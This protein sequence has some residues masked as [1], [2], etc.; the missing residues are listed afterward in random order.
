MLI[1]GRGHDFPI[2]DKRSVNVSPSGVVDIVLDRVIARY[3]TA[4]DEASGDQQLCSVADAA[5]DASVTTY[6]SQES[7]VLSHVF[8]CF[9]ATGKNEN[10]IN[11]IHWIHY[12]RYI[13]R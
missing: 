2:G 8:H 9:C 3:A 12:Y 6:V 5:N 11:P 4:F 1:V 10:V 7:Y 13:H